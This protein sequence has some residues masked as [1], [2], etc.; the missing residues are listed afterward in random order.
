M[1][2]RLMFFYIFCK[3]NKKMNITENFAKKNDR[4]LFATPSPCGWV[5]T[6]YEQSVVMA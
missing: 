1:G 2:V 6:T 4:W 3:S 5:V